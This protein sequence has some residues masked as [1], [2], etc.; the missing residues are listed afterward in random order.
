MEE[1]SQPTENTNQRLQ[2][3]AGCATPYKQAERAQ[4][5]GGGSA[6]TLNPLR[7]LFN[8]TIGEERAT[9][10]NDKTPEVSNYQA[11]ITDRPAAGPSNAEWHR[12]DPPHVTGQSDVALLI[13]KMRAQRESD[14]LLRNRENLLAVQKANLEEQTR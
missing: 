1:K 6:T 9:T 5:F 8:R 10:P 7:K 3:H 14:Q 12:S 2:G 11:R 4:I 13:T